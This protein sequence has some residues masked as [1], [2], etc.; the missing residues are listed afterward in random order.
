[1]RR[2]HRDA[3]PPSSPASLRG[4]VTAEF[5]LSVPAVILLLG[6]LLS[7]GSA[8]LCQVRVEEA[9]RAAARTIARGEG[10]PVIAR[11]VE[12]VAG[13]SAKHLIESSAGVVT[14]TVSAEVPGPLAT[15]VGLTAAAR[16]SLTIEAHQ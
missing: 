2:L 16:A 11:E 5:A 6:V 13:P 14:V 4:S 15:V 9:A 3:G 12:R 1:M 8:A 10:P 7:A